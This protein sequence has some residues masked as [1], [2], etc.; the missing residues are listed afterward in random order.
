MGWPRPPPGIATQ[1]CACE[2][3]AGGWGAPTT[4][5]TSPQNTLLGTDARETAAALEVVRP[6]VGLSSSEDLG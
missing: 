4:A 6:R 2:I 3:R 5:E 1:R